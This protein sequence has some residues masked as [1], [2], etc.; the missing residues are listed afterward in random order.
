MSNTPFSVRLPEELK[1]GL[2]F[3]S[4][5]THRSQAYLATQAIRDY[6]ARN[7]W[8]MEAIE[9]AKKEA[10]NGE[11]ISQQATEQWLDSWGSGKELP[12]PKANVFLK[13]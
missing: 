6:V 5:A 1:A 3:L 7:K 4:K 10:E 8:K 2:E 13:K 9:E 11:F 12:E